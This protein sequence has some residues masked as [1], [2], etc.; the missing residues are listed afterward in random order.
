[1]PLDRLV[2]VTGGKPEPVG[3]LT[4]LDFALGSLVQAG[5]VLVGLLVIV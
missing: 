5:V 2:E 4:S 3:L 1:M